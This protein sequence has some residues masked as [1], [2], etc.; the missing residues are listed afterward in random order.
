MRSARSA[1]RRWTRV[2]RVAWLVRYSASSAAV[3]PPPT[4]TTSLPRKKKPSQVAQADTP[5]PL[6]R[7]SLSRPSQRARAPVETMTA[8]PL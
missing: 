2:T 8:S 5:K 1:S 7:A 4:T 3:L 6:S